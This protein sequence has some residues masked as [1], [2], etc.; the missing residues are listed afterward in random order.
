VTYF[1]TYAAVRLA[2]GNRDALSQQAQEAIEL[3]DDL[4]ISPMVC[5][6]LE[7]L[8]EIKRLK[9][10]ATGVL[11]ILASEIGLSV[12]DAGFEDVARQ[13]MEERWT[14]DPFDRVIVAQARLGRA[15]L[16]T[17]DR[18]IQARYSHAIG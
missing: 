10:S 3:D 9:I 2:E 16:I 12:C 11:N 1:D 13:A 17:R 6:E 8:H 4:R 5:L 14:R 7:Y 15:T 18:S